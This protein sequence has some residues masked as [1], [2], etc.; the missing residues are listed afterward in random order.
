[1]ARTRR[2]NLRSKPGRPRGHIATSHRYSMRSIPGQAR[3]EGFLLKPASKRQTKP[4][5]GSIETRET[6][7]PEEAYAHLPFDTRVLYQPPHKWTPKHLRIANVE[8]EFDVPMDRILDAKYIPSDDDPGYGN[9]HLALSIK[10]QRAKK[11]VRVDDLIVRVDEEGLEVGVPLGVVMRKAEPGT[12]GIARYEIPFLLLQANMIFNFDQS[13]NRYEGF[14]IVVEG[15]TYTIVKAVVSP[16][17][18]RSVR[19]W[20]PVSGSFKVLR[21]VAFD[22]IEP[23]A[24][25]EFLKAMM[26]LIRYFRE[27]REFS[28]LLRKIH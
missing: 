26:A 4:A 28:F 3:S 7:P 11:G 10:A 1:M 5:V 19:A 14:L 18:V 20:K 16:E 25:K 23:E 17:Y 2:Y 15:Y 27:R 13:L 9:G 12:L 24:R 22:L 6:T 8:Q 21:S